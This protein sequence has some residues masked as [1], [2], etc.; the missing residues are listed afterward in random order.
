MADPILG[1]L[2]TWKPQKPPGPPAADLGPSSQNPG[3]SSGWAKACNGR[4]GSPD[5]SGHCSVGNSGSHALFL[6][7][8]SSSG[9]R[10]SSVFSFLDAGSSSMGGGGW[11]GGMG[12]GAGTGATGGAGTKAAGQER[13]AT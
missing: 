9:M 1:M 6:R 3:S 2:G 8:N 13:A 12:A 10:L 11:T 5:L 4:E 7:R